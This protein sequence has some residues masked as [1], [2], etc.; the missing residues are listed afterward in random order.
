MK[1]F[2]GKGGEG[3]SKE[4]L[5]IIVILVL[6]FLITMSQPD[7]P[8][9]GMFQFG[10]LASENLMWLIGMVAIILIFYFAYKHK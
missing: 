3:P 1:P 10:P 5:I 4:F 2:K 7:S 9:Y 6:L 8:L